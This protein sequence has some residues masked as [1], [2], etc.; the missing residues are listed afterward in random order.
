[1]SGLHEGQYASYLREIGYKSKIVSF[2]PQRDAYQVAICTRAALIQD[3]IAI[4]TCS[5]RE[6][7]EWKILYIAENGLAGLCCIYGQRQPFIEGG[8]RYSSERK[9]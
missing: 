6:A 9:K 3:W 8:L 4:N 5:R 1:M 7:T 2:E